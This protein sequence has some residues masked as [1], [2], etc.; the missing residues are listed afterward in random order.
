MAP[1][2]RL[3]EDEMFDPMLACLWAKLGR[4]NIGPDP[5]PACVGRLV[6]DA[7]F[8]FE[9]G[10]MATR[11]VAP[12]CVTFGCWVAILS[13]RGSSLSI[14]PA[15][16]G[17]GNCANLKSVEMDSRL[18]CKSSKL[19]EGRKSSGPGVVSPTSLLPPSRPKVNSEWLL[20]EEACSIG[21]FRIER[22][23]GVV[24]DVYTGLTFSF[25][26]VVAKTGLASVGPWLVASVE[27]RH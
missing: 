27:T 10:G 6:G 17:I 4:E 5:D 1:S 13:T 22:V 18:L 21:P 14:F 3:D 24:E 7:V 26:L 20:D 25:A 23:V 2:V 11:V 15:P 8:E 16:A 9:V 12:L 19:T